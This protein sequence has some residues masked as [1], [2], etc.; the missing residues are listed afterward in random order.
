MKSEKARLSNRPSRR[1]RVPLSASDRSVL[2]ELAVRYLEICHDPAQQQ[3]R[4]LWRQLHNLESTPPLIYVRA[5]A[6]SEM[7][8]SKCVCTDPLFRSVENFFRQSLFRYGFGDDFIFEPWVNVTAVYRC[9]GWGV[10]GTR[11]YSDEPRGSWK[12]DYPI[13]TYSDLNK[14]RSPWHEIDEEKQ[15]PRP[16]DC[17]T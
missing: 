16:T 3:K 1:R 10:E 13:K 7:P 15:R 11:R 12:M 5:F 17:R 9:Q 8:E 2:R 14:L 6:W 4:Q